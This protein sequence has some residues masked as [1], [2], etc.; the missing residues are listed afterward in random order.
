MQKFIFGNLIVTITE[1][2][3]DAKKEGR[4]ATKSF[5]IF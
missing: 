1:K 2:S 5:L 3:R 4:L